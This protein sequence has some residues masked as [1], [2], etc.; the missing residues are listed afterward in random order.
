MPDTPTVKTWISQTLKAMRL[1]SLTLAF[2]A[3]STGI[4]AAWRVW[5]IHF[6]LEKNVSTILYLFHNLLFMFHPWT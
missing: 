4:I 3:T 1:F 6:F 2:G 5:V